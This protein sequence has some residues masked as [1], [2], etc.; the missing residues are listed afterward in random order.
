MT[1]GMFVLVWVVVVPIVFVVPKVFV[2]RLPSVKNDQ[3]EFQSFNDYYGNYY[4]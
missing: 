2:L 3:D 4:R 1:G